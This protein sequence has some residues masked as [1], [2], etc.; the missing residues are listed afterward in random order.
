VKKV[1]SRM[2]SCATATAS[3]LGRTMVRAASA[4]SAS[5]GAFSNSVVTAAHVRAISSR[6]AG[7]V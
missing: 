7:S 6:E 5:A 3:P 1:F 4:F 2:R